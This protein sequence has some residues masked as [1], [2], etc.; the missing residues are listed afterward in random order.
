MIVSYLHY[1][2]IEIGQEQKRSMFFYGFMVSNRPDK[3]GKTLPKNPVKGGRGIQTF[4]LT[5]YFLRYSFNLDE[6]GL[7]R[8]DMLMFMKTLTVFQF[9]IHADC[10]WT[11]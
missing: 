10:F 6:R 8:K 9:K 7:F 11:C 2:D 3:H 5:H 4:D 1:V